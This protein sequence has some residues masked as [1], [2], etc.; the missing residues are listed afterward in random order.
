MNK[1]IRLLI[2]ALALVIV[3]AIL[4]FGRGTSAFSKSESQ[5]A[6]DDTSTVTRFFMVDK[7]GTS[8]LISRDSLHGGWIV[9]HS[10]KAHRMIVESFLGVASQLA[11]ESPV[12][13]KAAPIIIK[14][15]A[16]NGIKVE[17][18]QMKPLIDWF[19]L[20]LF[21]KERRTRTYYVGEVTSDN[22]GTYMLMEGA[23]LPFIVYQ[24][25]FRGFV[26]AR[27]FTNPYDWRN[28]TIFAVP[29]EDIK[30][31]SMEYPVEPE[32]SF[33]IVNNGDR[34]LSLLAG[35]GQVPVQ[36]FDTLRCLAYLTAF[37]SVNFEAFINDIT[38]HKRDSIVN[39]PPY[40][41]L[42]VTDRSGQITAMKAWKMETGEPNTEL[43]G[44]QFNMDRM[45][46][47]VGKNNELVM[48]QFFVFDKF[49]WKAADFSSQ[50]PPNSSQQ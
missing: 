40:F 2:V 20:N 39:S 7:K 28:H 13:E 42:S 12:P 18:Y 50:A 4:F 27:Y 38:Q 8:V 35:P 23:S 30:S 16:A 24:P 5:F 46:A 43:Y 14:N 31:V 1:N 3:A 41:M 48:I 44:H 29:L 6:I 19:G 10:F 15:M 49:L 37:H 32:S 34:S 47:M 26:Q 33:T 36:A 17:V 45:Y 21:V 25:G 22:T 11:V 9:N